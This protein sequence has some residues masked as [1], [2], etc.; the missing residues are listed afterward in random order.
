MS[1]VPGNCFLSRADVFASF[2]SRVKRYGPD[3][4][5]SVGWASSC[6][7]KGCQLDSRSGYIPGLQVQ[8]PVRGAYTVRET[9]LSH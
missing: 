7:G 2:M 9:A 8:F 6:K 1:F 5:V 3:W 4:C